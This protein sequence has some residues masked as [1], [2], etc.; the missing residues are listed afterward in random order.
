M[1]KKE[2]F[3]AMLRDELAKYNVSIV[4][5]E[6][7]HEVAKTREVKPSK[8]E[9]IQVDTELFLARRTASFHRLRPDEV[10]ELNGL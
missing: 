7:G 8:E 4:T 6:G 5:Y 1:T 2:K 3:D 9:T 10:A